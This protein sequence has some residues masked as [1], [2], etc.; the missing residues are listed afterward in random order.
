M[1]ATTELNTVEEV[2]RVIDLICA[3]DGAELRA[4]KPAER[5]IRASR[6][7]DLFEIRARY[8]HE[9][10]VNAH[11]V[12]TIPGVY[13]AACA[14]AERSDRDSARFWRTQAGAR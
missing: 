7:A 8:W 4:M 12:D 11:R 3:I 10:N 13:G 9:L 2:S 6:L 14:L 5:R 1:D